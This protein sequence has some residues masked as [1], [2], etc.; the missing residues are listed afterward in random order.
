MLSESKIKSVLQRGTLFII[1]TPIGNLADITLRG[2]DTLKKVDIIAAE[3]TRHSKKLLGH[4][5][6]EKPLVSF[7][8]HNKKGKAPQIIRRLIDGKSIGLISDAGTPAI[9]DPGF[10]LIREAILSEIPVVAIPG[11]TALI[12][13]LVLSGLPIHRFAFEGFPPQKKGRKTFFENLQSE[14]R[15]LIFYESPHRLLRTLLDIKNYLGERRVA[16]ARELTKKFEEIIRAKVTDLIKRIEKQPLKGEIVIVV[17][18]LN[19]KSLKE[20]AINED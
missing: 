17:E 6:I 15:T 5:N 9:S 1:S 18:G 3:D 4:Y 16:L 19:K 7:H 13:A 10:Y 11:A 20:K 8:E 12:P 14:S 2:L